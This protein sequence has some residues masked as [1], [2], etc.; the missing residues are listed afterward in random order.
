MRADKA[1]PAA[2]SSGGV[3]YKESTRHYVEVEHWSNR[4][5]LQRLAQKLG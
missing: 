5:E 2:G 3:Q 1:R 4:K